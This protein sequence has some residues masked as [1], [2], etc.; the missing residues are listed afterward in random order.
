MKIA[1]RNLMMLHKY[2]P[3]YADFV[4]KQL[5]GCYV[6]SEEFGVHLLHDAHM[7]DVSVQYSQVTSTAETLLH[8]DLNS[9]NLIIGKNIY[10]G[11]EL[12]RTYD[13]LY[14]LNFI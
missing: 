3:K 8:Y 12:V 13:D 14:V 4:E 11:N 6:Y 1:K 2:S 10:R 5:K 7:D 9:S